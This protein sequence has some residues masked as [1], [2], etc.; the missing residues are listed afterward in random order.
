MDNQKEFEQNR[1]KMNIKELNGMDTLSEQTKEVMLSL[2]EFM[3]S[4]TPEEVNAIMDDFEKESAIIDKVIGDGKAFPLLAIE[5]LLPLAENISDKVKADTSNKELRNL[6]NHVC[7]VM[8]ANSQSLI[9]EGEEV[10]S[11][12]SN[13]LSETD[14]ILSEK[15]VL[16]AKWDEYFHNTL[17]QVKEDLESK[18]S[19]K[20]CDH[21]YNL[22]GLSNISAIFF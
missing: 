19:L 22:W 14:A 9:K 4:S 2:D 17:G 21:C 12:G 13:D 11:D 1:Q 18:D 20:L 6:L 7:D 16:I 10:P 3:K 5:R 8:A 15:E